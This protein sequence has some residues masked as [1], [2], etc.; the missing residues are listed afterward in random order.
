MRQGNPLSPYLFNLAADYLTRMVYRAQSLNLIQG[1]I[2]HLVSPGI[3]ILQCADDTILCF[4]HDVEKAINLK[5]LLY[6]F[7]MMSGLKINFTKS[8][9]Y[10]AAGD[11]NI[12]QHYSD[13]FGCNVGEIPFTYLGVPVGGVQIT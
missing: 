7:E 8:E 11:N 9:L 6:T 10:L 4:A 3:A 5:L 12:A 2:P 13:V 1:L